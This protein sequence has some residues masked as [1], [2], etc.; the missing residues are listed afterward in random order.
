MIVVIVVVLTQ[1]FLLDTLLQMY[2]SVSFLFVGSRKFTAA[3]VTAEGLFT[4]VSTD[5]RC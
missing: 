4:G 1:L 2:L 3:G 5:M